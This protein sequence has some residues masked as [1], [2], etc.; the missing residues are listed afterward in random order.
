MN[1]RQNQNTGFTATHIV[2]AL[3]GGAAVGASIALLTA[4]RSGAETRADLRRLAD[5]AR[6]RTVGLPHALAGA[7]EAGSDAFATSLAHSVKETK[8]L[9]HNAH[10]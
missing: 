7:V 6:N 2:V 10:A 3:L 5:N 1:D 4:P 8:A 9:K